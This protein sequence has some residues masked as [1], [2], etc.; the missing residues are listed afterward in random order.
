[1]RSSIFFDGMLWS[2]DDDE[3]GRRQIY[4]RTL[5]LWGDDVLLEVRRTTQTEKI[6]K[7]FERYCTACNTLMQLVGIVEIILP[8]T[9][10]SG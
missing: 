7:I 5:F 4:L 3:E 1:M 9:L 10:I 6:K 8:I 2:A